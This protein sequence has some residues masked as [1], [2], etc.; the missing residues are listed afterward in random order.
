MLAHNYTALLSLLSLAAL[1][2]GCATAQPAAPPVPGGEETPVYGGI[3][4]NHPGN[5]DPPSFDS[6]Y[7]NTIN[8]NRPVASAHNTLVRFSQTEADKT[9]PDLTEKWE[10]SPDGKT[11]TFTLRKGVKFHN[12]DDF[13][14]ADVKFN[15]DRLRGVITTGPGALVSPPRKDLLRAVESIDTPDPSTAVLRLQYPSASL[16]AY[17]AS[18]FAPMYG[19][20]W[21]EAG[22]DPKK[23]VNGTG[24][25]KFKEYIRGT[26]VELVKNDNYWNKGLP[27]L[28][29]VKTY[30]IPDLSTVLASVRAG[31]VM[32]MQLSQSQYE[33]LRPQVAGGDLK[34]R[35]NLVN[36]PSISGGTSVWVNTNRKPF[37]DLRV[38]QA[39]NLAV[40]RTEVAKIQGGPDAVV[41]G[42]LPA[43][44]FFALPPEELAK[45][46][47]YGPDKAA[48]RAE[49]R[50]LLAE[51]GYPNGLTL[52]GMTRN[53][54][55]YID[56]GIVYADQFKKVGITVEP[57]EVLDISVIYQRYDARDFEIS[58]A[59]G[60]SGTTED[61]D[62]VFG[63][64][65][66][67]SSPR[68]YVGI[69]DPK[70]E[71]LFNRQAQAIDPQVRQ[72]LSWELEKLVLNLVPGLSNASSSPVPWA[73]NAQVRGLG[74]GSRANELRL[75]QAWLAK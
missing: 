14:S 52:K 24:P 58:F 16:L 64:F 66:I 31:Q 43:G 62:T 49:A 33:T 26:S 72:K 73:V 28:D 41:R 19:K 54:Q 59:R 50:R 47:G 63:Q 7:E 61:P 30:I 1:V 34:G 6:Q 36:V 32:F 29:V 45:M 38:R 67:C 5:A 60:G 17:L 11:L 65:H 10:Y 23:E 35:L 2:M 39:L 40:D 74:L 12:G 53:E 15:L 48:E 70:I 3:F 57:V 75:E 27:Y 51:A 55:S 69:C 13:T 42:W 68:N 22:H 21:V 4:N 8:L 9:V 20:K 56:N 46:P 25:F 18:V 71:D 44:T 37:D